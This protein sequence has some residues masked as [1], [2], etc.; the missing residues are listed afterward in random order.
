[1]QVLQ[2]V[3]SYS[4]VSRITKGQDGYINN[5]KGQNMVYGILKDK[6]D[7]EYRVV[8]TP[9]AVRT[10]VS[11]GHRVIAEKGCGTSAG[12]H[13]EDY[14]NAGAEIANSV[15]EIFLKCDLVAKVKEFTPEEIKLAK[16]GQ[17]LLGCLHPAANPEEVDELL[18]SGC[19]AFTAEDSHREGSP[20]CEAAGKQGA[21]FGLESMLTTNGGKGKY[22]GGFAGTEP[23]RVLILGAGQVGV[24]ALSVLHSLGA[25]CTVMDVSVGKLRELSYKY[26]GIA[27]FI[28]TKEKIAELLPKTDLVV[29]CVKWQKE[30]KDYLIDR[31]MLSLM[32]KGSVIVDIS[33]D[34][35]GAIESSHPT[36]HNEPRYT[37]D[38]VVHYCVSNIPSAVANSSSLSYSA[39]MLPFIISLLGDGAEKTC[40]KNGYYRR[41]LTVYEGY[42]THEETSAIQNKGWIRPED[43]LN[44]NKEKMDKAPSQTSTRSCNFIVLGEKK[45]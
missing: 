18:K 34:D 23:I 27:T 35:P 25:I 8:T 24:G 41:S 15:S 12:F 38:G 6:K 31:K 37:V 43:I 19:I 30:R 42:L 5:K 26:R 1:M 45:C 2:S 32:E 17:I 10:I 11:M 36:N 13:D 22:V 7:G 44:L 14:S 16:H 9:D 4:V 20:N 3:F 21:L 28:S 29:N 39:E 33:N 40:E